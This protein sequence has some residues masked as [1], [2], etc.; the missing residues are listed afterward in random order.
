MNLICTIPGN[1]THL[2]NCDV[3]FNKIV[4]TFHI[5]VSYPDDNSDIDRN[6]LVSS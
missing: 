3:Q 5:L 6:T 4:W 1:E 2:L